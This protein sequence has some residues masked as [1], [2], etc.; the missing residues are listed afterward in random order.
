MPAPIPVEGLDAITADVPA[1]RVTAVLTALGGTAGVRYAQRGALV[2]ADS[3]KGNIGF[4]TS[5]IPQAWTWTTG[6]P[7]ITV[8]VVDSGVSRTVDLTADR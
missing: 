8:A 2:Q 4:D 3:E 5:E 6:S 1:D 7:D